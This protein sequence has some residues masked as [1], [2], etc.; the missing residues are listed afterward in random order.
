MTV[1]TQLPDFEKCTIMVV[2]DL[3][4]DEY[5]WGRVDRISPE[6]P[7][8]VVSVEREG[9]TLGGAGNVVNNL[10]ALG[11]VVLAAGVAGT[12]ENG[13]LLFGKF[14]ELG[15]DTT[16]IIRDPGR[17]TTRKTRVLAANQHVMRIDRETKRQISIRALKA[18][19]EYIEAKLPEVDLVVISDYGKGLLT[20]ELLETVIRTA[21]DHD[22]IV[23][24]DPKGL[25]YSKYSGATMLTPN[26]K[27]ASLASGIEILD[28]ESLFKAGNRIL[29]TAMVENLLLTCGK[30]GMVLFRNGKEPFRIE[31]EARQVFDVSGA[32]DTV[33]S[34]FAL[35]LASG[36]TF[37]DAARLANTAAG[38]VVGK[39]GTAT[40]S[41]E[42][43]DIALGR[44]SRDVSLK[45]K[46]LRELP[47][48][49]KEQREKGNRIILTNGCF[50]LLHAGHIKLFSASKRLGDVLI[51]A[52][53]DDDS[54]RNLKGQGRPVIGEKER[55]RVISALDS[56]DYVV[57]FSG[58][59]LEKLI[60]IIRPDILAKGSNYASEE[61]VGH[62]L[63]KKFGGSVALIQVTEDVSSTGI[64]QNIK[65]GV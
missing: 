25:H 6:A 32:G 57:I 8:Q 35:A 55:V 61:V 28:D 23:I 4:I 63:V 13:N 44:D 64:I 36:K 39:L 5:L 29:E 3:M 52:I 19:M 43:L 2:G 58:D 38:I 21:K 20:D 37:E 60:E 47:F 53:D 50:D 31:T 27:E 33:I 24:V 10:A 54:V 40:V 7:V 65:S 48:L 18:L 26:K 51:V 56:V 14:L 15:V 22:K 1:E 46:S 59:E 34:V 30:D 12:G 17:Y 42:E 41:R 9:F 45:H 16:G 49:L 11:A 62:E